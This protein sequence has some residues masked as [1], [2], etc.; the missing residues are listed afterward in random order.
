[1]AEIPLNLLLEKLSDFLIAEASLLRG[2]SD[3][4]GKIKLE[5]ESMQ[6][7]LRDADRRRV[8]GD[9]ELKT[10]VRQVREAAYETEVFLTEFVYRMPAAP[11]S[12]GFKSLI[13]RTVRLPKKIYY[14][15]RFATRL[16]E[17]SASVAEIAARRNR[18]NLNR[19]EE[20]T[21]L[22]DANE[23]WKPSIETAI[24]QEEDGI[25][26]MKKEFD[27]ILKWLLEGDERLAVISVTGMGG[28][29]KTT[30]VSKAF[31]HSEVKKEFN[32]F[33]YVSV[34]QTPRI[35]ELIRSIIKQLLESNMNT[36]PDHLAT[37]DTRD[38]RQLIE[39]AWEL[40]HKKAFRNG[41][42]PSNLESLALRMAE[43]CE[44]LPLAISAL[45]SLFMFPEDHL[46]KLKQLIR[47]WVAEGFVKERVGMTMEEVAEEYVKEL[48]HRSMLLVANVNDYG[49][50]K[51][52][53][54]H[55]M[56]REVAISLS[57]NEDFSLACDAPDARQLFQFRCIAMY[58]D[59][60]EIVEST[61]KNSS[62]LR[63]VIVFNNN[64][65]TP[66]F[67]SLHKMVSSFR[68]LRVLYLKGAQ[69]ERVPNELVELFNL[70]YL[71]LAKTG[72]TELPK[73]FGKLRNLLTLDLRET[74]VE[75]L[76]V[77]IGKL[78]KLRHLLCFQTDDSGYRSFH[79]WK[80]CQF[81][82]ELCNITSLQ[83]LKGI[84]AEGET[85]R[86]IGKLVQLRNFCIA[87]V[88]ASDGIELCGS[89]GKMKNL[90]KLAIIGISEEETLELE[91][92]SSSPPSLLQKVEL[93]GHLK[94]VPQWLASLTNLASLWLNRSRLREEEGERDG[95]LSTLQALPNLVKL[96][97]L[98][99]YDGQKL[100]F[101]EGWFPKLQQLLLI[102]LTELRQL[103]MEKGAMPCLQKLVLLSCRELK[104]AQG[105]E[106]LP[107]LQELYL[108]EIPA[109]LVD[110]FRGSRNKNED[111][112]GDK[113]AK[114]PMIRHAWKSGEGKW[115]TE[116]IE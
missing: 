61:D 28:L 17:I 58:D 24:F 65:E 21:G 1:M 72:I 35:T 30:L 56:M 87:K 110:S 53:R 40:F 112:D 76:P 69:I 25:V 67:V 103:V 85:I 100:L 97:L 32:C 82:R 91:A 4:L 96:D 108:E 50:L 31:K 104:V 45:G 33:A 29:G 44:G 46:I 81:P 70:T 54:M 37:M 11:Q 66:F 15:H 60:R 12:R 109:E 42:C 26:G 3:E 94:K 5:L 62:H 77:A 23:G 64:K 115:N 57:R 43:K 19:I 27:L 16:Q 34:S 88:R 20:G 79:F 36:A 48:I 114:L 93:I 107:T 13:L 98:Q 99:A 101:K 75:K 18:Y 51:A 68:F 113:V 74:K 89:I 8:S 38:L 86:Q 111:E 73:S 63:S 71:N 41:P 9:E 102:D 55:D 80:F 7:F 2:V 95:F 39:E 52:C 22:H 90:V 83:S 49:R 92:L 116:T 59:S 105:I 84:E 47:L 6:A 78:Q 10:W 14:K 106:H